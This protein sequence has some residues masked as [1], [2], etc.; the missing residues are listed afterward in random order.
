MARRDLVLACTPYVLQG[1]ARLQ[2]R[3]GRL[4]RTAGIQCELMERVA[5]ASRLQRAL[6]P[7]GPQRDGTAEAAHHALGGPAVEAGPQGWEA[8]S[9][10]GEAAFNVGP[11]GRRG[12]VDGTH[13]SSLFVARARGELRGR[14][15]PSAT[16]SPRLFWSQ[17]SVEESHGYWEASQKTEQ[18]DTRNGN[19]V[20]VRHLQLP[21]E[22]NW[23][24]QDEHVDDE[25]GDRQRVVQ[26]LL[27]D[28]A[29]AWIARA[30]VDVDVHW[31][32]N[33][34]QRKEEASSPY[35]R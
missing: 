17:V 14:R 32:T 19:L 24:D 10:D 31:G 2:P 1:H 4:R 22:R 9:G 26:L 7:N 3:A 21:D 13:M 33:E 6:A 5:V 35:G 20:L 8:G 28:A 15:R 16:G 25:V 12:A 11:D 30:V 27:V 23:N 18:E 29:D 34:E